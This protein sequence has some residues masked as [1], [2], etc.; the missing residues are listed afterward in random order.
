[1][2]KGVFASEIDLPTIPTEWRIAGAGD[3]L[4]IGQADLVL[5]NTTTGARCIWVMQ[6][7]V[8]V[9]EID[10]PTVATEWEILDH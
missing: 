10:L 9:S 7:G 6:N 1:M 5:E 2:Q 8:L 3:F 4:G